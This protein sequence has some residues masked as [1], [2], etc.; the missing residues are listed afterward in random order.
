MRCGIFGKYPAKR[1]F[2]A[3]NLPRPF[4]SLWEDWLQTSVA[5][6]RSQLGSAWQ[7]AFLT[8]PLWRFWIGGGLCGATVA[9]VMMP[10]VDGIGRYFPLTVCA[11]APE[12]KIIEPPMLDPLEEWYGAAEAALLRVLEDGFAGEAAELADALSFPVLNDRPERHETKGSR[13]W[14]SRLLGGGFEAEFRRVVT[15]ELLGLY[16][17]RSVWWTAGGAARSAEFV[18][19]HQLPDP[20]AYAEFL[21]G[22]SHGGDK[23]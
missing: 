3:Y 13:V 23:P 22:V 20:F 6:S 21:T 12:G 14:Q 7:E 18:A 4:L 1:D 8:A 16:D 9:G 11:C 5:A 15:A 2:V 10:S 17:M 19:Y